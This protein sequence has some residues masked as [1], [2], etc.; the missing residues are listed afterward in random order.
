MIR[1]FKIQVIFIRNVY[2]FKKNTYVCKKTN[3]L[4]WIFL[5]I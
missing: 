3:T 4:L 5:M 2:Q 1:K